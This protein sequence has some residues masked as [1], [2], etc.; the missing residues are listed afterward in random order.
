[1]IVTIAQ[2][3]KDYGFPMSMKRREFAFGLFSIFCPSFVFAQRHIKIRTELSL[4][5]LDSEAEQVMKRFF[6][7]YEIAGERK[8]PSVAGRTIY[9]LIR[10]K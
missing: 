8:N 4:D 9:K 5:V 10:N 7:D 3:A 1:M 6:P 2:I